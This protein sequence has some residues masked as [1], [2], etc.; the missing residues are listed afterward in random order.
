M[1]IGEPVAMVVGETAAAAQDAAEFVTV[2]YEELTP[3]TDAREALRDGAPELWPQ[4][5][6]NIAVDW[7]GPNPDP[8]A[9]VRA[10]DAALASAK[11]VAKIAVFISGR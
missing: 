7:L 2:E 3:V 8:D 10:V 1:H 9:N 11:F 6:G 5:P 4:A